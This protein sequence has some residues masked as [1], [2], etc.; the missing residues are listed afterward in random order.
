[1]TVLTHWMQDSRDQAAPLRG[2]WN[3]AGQGSGSQG[4]HSQARLPGEPQAFSTKLFLSHCLHMYTEIFG[5]QE[6][7]KQVPG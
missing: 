2:L 5:R 7:V 6:G 1:M 4:I 3:R